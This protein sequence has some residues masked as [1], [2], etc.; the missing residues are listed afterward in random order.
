MTE[1]SGDPEIVT[2]PPVTVALHRESVRMD[3]LPDFFERGYHAIAAA[4]E[5]QGVL[6]TGPPMGIYYG[7][8]SDTVDVAAAF[9]TDRAVEATGDVAS[10]ILPAGDAARILHIGSYDSLQKTYDRLLSWLDE[11][12][13]RGGPLA[14]ETYL[15]EP[16]PDGDQGS[17]Q[18]LI[19]WPLA[20]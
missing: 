14:W 19:V 5:S 11:Q 7:V 13:R 9:P 8:P 12:G 20:D 6:A 4:L 18:T 17:M 15:T 3:E 10:E 2:Q 1:P 16:A